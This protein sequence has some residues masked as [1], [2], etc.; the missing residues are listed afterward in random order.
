MTFPHLYPLP[1]VKAEAT[2]ATPPSLIF[3]PAISP[4]EV[5]KVLSG[6]EIL[7][8]V[9]DQ[10]SSPMVTRL[11]QQQVEL[12]GVPWEGVGA[13]GLGSIPLPRADAYCP[14]SFCPPPR[15]RTHLRQENRN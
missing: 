15:P 1:G 6:L 2:L 12:W 11:L 13:L 7:S 4:S 8:K 5:D 9:F 3:H 14:H 10:Q